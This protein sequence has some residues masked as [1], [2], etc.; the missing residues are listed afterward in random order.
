M[1][2]SNVASERPGSPAGGGAESADVGIAT[3]SGFCSRCNEPDT[4]DGVDTLAGVEILAATFAAGAGDAE[5]EEEPSVTRYSFALAPMPGTR[6]I[7]F[8]PVNA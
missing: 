5:D 1:S 8:R 3:P 4:A 6:E 7:K 2:P